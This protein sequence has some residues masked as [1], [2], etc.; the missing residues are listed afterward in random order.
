MPGPVPEMVG[1]RYPADP[2]QKI[3]SQ[4]LADPDLGRGLGI[5]LDP[6]PGLPSEACADQEPVRYRSVQGSAAEGASLQGFVVVASVAP[7]AAVAI[8]PAVNGF[9]LSGFSAVLAVGGIFV[10]E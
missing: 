7:P 3:G 1:A 5:H 6:E 2:C 4:D 9:A 8:V 10:A